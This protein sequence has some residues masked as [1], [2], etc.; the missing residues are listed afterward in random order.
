MNANLAWAPLSGRRRPVHPGA[1]RAVEPGIE[2]PRQPVRH[3]RHGD[4][5]RSPRWRRI[6]R[7]ASAPGRSWSCGHRHRRRHR[8]RDGAARADD[9]DA[10]AGRRLPFAGR[11]GGGAG[12]GRRA[13]CAGAFDIGTAGAIHGASLVEM[14]L[15]VAIGAITFTGSVI[16]FLKLSGRMS[17]T[18]IMLPARHVINIA[19]A[20]ALDLLHLGSSYREATLDVLADRA[21]VLRARR[22]D[23]HSDRRRRHAGRDLDA[24]LL[25]G[26]GG[27]RHRLHARQLGA[28]HHRRA[29]RLVRRDP[30]LHHVQGHEPQL[31][32]GDPRRL[33]RRGRGPGGRQGGSGRSSTA[34]PRMPPSC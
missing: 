2:P 18:P 23:H 13:L 1:A 32:L 3:D 17:G 25:F 34:R 12:R 8:R 28:D 21:G 30:V 5:D 15:G 27:G 14:S 24:Q 31:L 7:P 16:A 11:H 29:G 22:A 20:L 6:R 4:R 19:L 10:G 9:G 26:L 33:R